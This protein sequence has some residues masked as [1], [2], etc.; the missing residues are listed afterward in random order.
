MKL[1][2]ISFRRACVSA[3]PIAGA[4][5]LVAVLLARSP[6][7]AGA[8]TLR[9]LAES[10]MSGR[11]L[12]GLSPILTY[13]DDWAD[14]LH[15]DALCALHPDVL[16][17]PAGTHAMY[18]DWETGK[19]TGAARFEKGG[20]MRSGGIGEFFA[21]ARKCNARVSYVVNL[22]Q[23]K[24]EKTRRLAEKIKSSGWSVA[25]W[26]LGNELGA[27]RYHDV[28][29]TV[30]TYMK[31]AR[32]HAAA[33]RAVFPD[34]KLAVC[35]EPGKMRSPWNKGLARQKDFDAVVI[36]RYA[37][38]NRQKR[39]EGKADQPPQQS[40]SEML[41]NS[42]PDRMS[43]EDDFPGK[44]IWLTEWGLFYMRT[45]IQNSLA[46]GIWM[47]RSF[48]AVARETSIRYASYW[49][50][51]SEAFGMTQADNG[52]L[53]HSVPE[54]VYTLLNEAASGAVATQALELD[55]GGTGANQTV[56]QQFRRADGSKTILGVNASASP[57]TVTVGQIV[58][59]PV[60]IRTVAAP[61]YRES[62]GYKQ[63]R[64]AALAS[65][66]E[67]RVRIVESTSQSA[68]VT[69]P[70]YSVVVVLRGK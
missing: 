39:A 47:A 2:K 54:H 11:D 1:G 46:H 35:S 51:N 25:Y 28:F 32:D 68:E 20:E 8:G 27:E 16:R 21:L 15:P 5:A 7:A 37:G 58:R 44:Q 24:P 41:T 22:Y 52:R 23:D 62:N 50:Y 55:A 36:H 65:P 53:I 17:F 19:Y 26:E 48:V 3:L 63:A 14:N 69:L 56:L 40:Y 4:I 59:P 66:R 67:E 64:T 30:D 31:A 33:I 18:F 49:N 12:M 10:S 60:R 57:V 34:A 61:D 9:P 42:G 13:A 38:P 70:P 45:D 43:Y 6:D 29:P